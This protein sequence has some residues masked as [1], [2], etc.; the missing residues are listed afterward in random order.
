M[1]KKILIAINIIVFIL[2]IAGVYFFL[3]FSSEKTPNM[4]PEEIVN[5]YPMQPIEEPIKDPETPAPTQGE[6]GMQV[7]TKDGETISV[8]DFYRDSK[9]IVYKD[10]GAMLKVNPNYKLLYFTLDQSFLVTLIGGDLRTVRIEAEKELLN[11][12]GITEK[13]ACRLIVATTVPFDVSERA[14][15]QDY[16]LSFCPDGA[17]LPKNI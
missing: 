14:S 9:T 2:V 16:G 3:K 13:E 17:P 11:I 12:L 4:P 5:T 7:K 6:W 8:N 10:W 1:N 15:G